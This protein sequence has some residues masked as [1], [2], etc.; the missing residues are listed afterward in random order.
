MESRKEKLLQDA[1]DKLDLAWELNLFLKDN[2]ETNREEFKASQKLTEILNANGIPTNLGYLGIPTA[3]YGRIG[4][5]TSGPNIAIIFE[6]D[7][8][9]GL[10]HACGHCAS[11]AIS[12]LASLALESTGGIQGANIHLVGTPAEE[13]D[14]LKIPMA[15]AGAFDDYDMAIMVHMHAENRLNCNFLAYHTY[16]FTFKG[17]ASHA[18][19][20]PWDGANAFNGMSLMIHAFD[21]MRQKLRDGSRIE[22]LVMEAGDA[23]NIIPDLARARYSFRAKD[24]AYLMGDFDKMVREAALGS[25]MATQTE[26]EIS[27]VGYTYYDLIESPRAI[28]AMEEVYKEMGLE[29]SSHQP[30]LG[31]SDIGNVSYRCPAI[32]PTISIGQKYNLHTHEFASAM[33]SDKTKSAILKGAMVILSYIDKI[34]DDKEMLETIKKEF[35]EK[36]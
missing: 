17:K 26:V 23:P 22:G 24:A 8:L 2:P 28:K 27:K 4:T 21:M 6:Y 29:I 3:F 36:R 7:A 35:K 34:I 12:L 18:A 30:F 1:K 10:G 15:E 20:S 11:A 33:E 9:P 31:S 13:G 14:G 32:H 16:D 25:A 5:Q 19:E